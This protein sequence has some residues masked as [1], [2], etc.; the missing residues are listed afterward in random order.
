MRL[1]FLITMAG[2]AFES[3]HVNALISK[4]IQNNVRSFISSNFLSSKSIWLKICLIRDS[5]FV[6]L[7]YT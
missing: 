4:F 2:A 5:S 1:F 3:I 6:I 7:S